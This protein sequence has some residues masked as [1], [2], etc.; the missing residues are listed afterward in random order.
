MLF[1]TTLYSDE[2]QDGEVEVEVDGRV[3]VNEVQVVSGEAEIEGCNMEGYFCTTATERT[4]SHTRQ[5]GNHQFNNSTHHSPRDD[6]VESCRKANNKKM[7]RYIKSTCSEK[8]HTYH[9][10]YSSRKGIRYEVISI[11]QV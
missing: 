9:T 1:E 2:R 4:G 5:Q 3:E 8:M 6:D 11:Y 7:A 10:S